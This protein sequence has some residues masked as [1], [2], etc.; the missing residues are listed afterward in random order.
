MSEVSVMSG[1]RSGNEG[2][3]RIRKRRMADAYG[4]L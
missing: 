1:G 2:G 4:P 3:K